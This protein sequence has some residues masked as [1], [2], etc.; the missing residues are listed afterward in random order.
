MVVKWD[1]LDC[2]WALPV[3]LITAA[4]GR[5]RPFVLQWIECAK[6]LKYDYEVFD[7]GGLGFGTPCVEVDENFHKYG[8]YVSSF[9]AWPTRALFKPR[10]VAA[11]LAKSREPIVWLDADAWPMARLDGALGDSDV[12]LVRRH[13]VRPIWSRYN[14]GVIFFAPNEA[15]CA[16]V[17]EWE[18]ATNAERN[19]QLALNRLITQRGYKVRELPPEY[20]ADPDHVGARV[21]HLRGGKLTRQLGEDLVNPAV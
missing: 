3:K 19:D 7:L 10:V 4:N 5:F 12:A 17:A 21:I 6:L 9:E 20:N 13:G 18:L 2:N 16:F 15:A 8:A 1:V 14:A 11:G